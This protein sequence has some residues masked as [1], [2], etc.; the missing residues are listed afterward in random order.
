[1]EGKGY[2][3]QTISFHT[4]VTQAWSVTLQKDL[5]WKEKIQMK[6]KKFLMFFF[7]LIFYIF[8]KIIKY[9]LKIPEFFLFSKLSLKTPQIPENSWILGEVETLRGYCFIPALR[10]VTWSSSGSSVKCGILLAHSTNVKSCLSAAWQMF[11]TGSL[12]R[13]GKHQEGQKHKRSPEQKWF[14]G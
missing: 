3:L 8:S 14:S 9:P 4:H 2:D 11:V 1:M 12:C 6:K 5:R 10:R 7:P 13:G